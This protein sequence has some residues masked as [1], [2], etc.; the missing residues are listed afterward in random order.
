MKLS[1]QKRDKQPSKE[2]LSLIRKSA[3]VLIDFAQ[4]WKKVQERGY[5]EGFDE[6]ELREM[7]RPYLKQKLT[8]AQIRH[9]FDPIYYKA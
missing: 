3:K 2:L 1:L 9:L 8:T 6:K 5:S 4:V 7:V